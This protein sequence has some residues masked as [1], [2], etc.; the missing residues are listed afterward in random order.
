[1][2]DLLEPIII[3]IGPTGKSSIIN[4]M[5][6]EIF[7][8]NRR[9]DVAVDIMSP[10]SNRISTVT[11]KNTCTIVDT[12]GLESDDFKDTETLMDVIRLMSTRT[13]S[14]ILMV[15]SI[16][17]MSVTKKNIIHLMQMFR[18]NAGQMNFVMN[19]WD[20]VKRDDPMKFYTNYVKECCEE[21]KIK[22]DLL[23]NESKDKSKTLLKFSNLSNVLKPVFKSIIL[24]SIKN[25]K[26]PEP[27]ELS[28]YHQSYRLNL[29]KERQKEVENK[30][31]RSWVRTKISF[32]QE[33][34]KN[35]S[36][37][38]VKITQGLLPGSE[39]VIVDLEE[40]YGTAD[41]IINCES[42]RVKHKPVLV[43]N[44]DGK[45]IAEGEGTHFK[46]ILYKKWYEIWVNYK[47]T[48]TVYVNSLEFNKEMIS[49]LE[50]QLSEMIKINDQNE[51]NIQDKTIKTLLQ[52]EMNQ[53]TYETIQLIQN[54]VI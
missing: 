3:L 45:F 33:R 5:L 24:E 27:L 22:V 23:F 14:L 31:S 21:A 38:R 1:M 12:P 46:I 34:I 29:L 52:L 30:E 17:R 54:T 49:I 44:I 16:D 32:L 35:L 40:S 28:E 48:Y 53:M 15:S 2:S 26:L 51:I 36:Q 50:K 9:M 6:E 11:I 19:K 25:S 47:G 20:L 42:F 8:H 39:V 13:L 4:Y 43:K 7:Q 41:I 10:M 18:S 37:G